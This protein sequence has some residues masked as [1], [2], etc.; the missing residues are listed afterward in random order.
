MG[1]R[2]L[3]RKEKAALSLLEGH[4]HGAMDREMTKQISKPLNPGVR[5]RK[6]HDATNAPRKAQKKKGKKAQE[7]SQHVTKG[8]ISIPPADILNL[9]LQS[10]LAQLADPW[11][12]QGIKCPVNY[13]PVP[14]FMTTPAHTTSTFM[15]AVAADRQRQI[16]LFP[17]HGYATSADSMD[18]VS[19]H[20]TTQNIGGTTYSIGPITTGGFP[21]A[22]GFIGTDA[23]YSGTIPDATLS[24]TANY[25]PITIDVPLPYTGSIGNGLH[26]RWKLL[27]MGIEVQN[28]TAVV[29]RG[30]T[31]M[32]V[33]P[34]T[35]V[36]SSGAFLADF[37]AQPT[38][39][40]SD[41]ANSRPYKLSWI[42]RA[43]DLSFWHSEVGTANASVCVPA[44]ILLLQAATTGQQ[45]YT[46]EVVCNWELSG[47]SL[48]AV[49]SAVLHQPA[50]KNI[51]EPTLSA[52]GFTKFDAK[53]AVEI[54]KTVAH[55][56]GPWMMKNLPKAAGAVS[57]ITSMFSGV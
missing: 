42:P 55:H 4:T 22:I 50:D 44:I 45:T 1:Q 37:G 52:L 23:I 53:A 31:I 9:R 54:G 8:R 36:I 48:A 32:H 19:Y 40:V 6:G 2:N 51:V 34:N 38:F 46:I 24:S 30:G 39:R 27:S 11:K 21:P 3:T 35:N 18:G 16:V 56:A 20:C 25:L 15:V 14:S 43:E 12:Y 41:E 47:H 29:N 13:N 57:A 17:G 49:S 7:G 28:T 26:T 33:M 10:Y 5:G